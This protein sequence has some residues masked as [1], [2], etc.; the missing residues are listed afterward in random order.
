VTELARPTCQAPARIEITRQ[1]LE[2]NVID[3]HR[4]G[5][6]IVEPVAG[7]QLRAKTLEVAE[8]RRS[9]E[10]IQHLDVAGWMIAIGK[11]V[12]QSTREGGNI[13][14]V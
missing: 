12:A 2:L 1:A 6:R 10:H 11:L 13:V 7:G 14:S 9:S 3:G 5:W 4:L 8:P